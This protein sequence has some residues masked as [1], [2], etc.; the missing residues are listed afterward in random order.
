MK[1]IVKL[2]AGPA[3]L[4]AALVFLFP[5]QGQAQVRRWGWGAP[6]YSYYYGPGYG[7]VYRPGYRYYYY[8]NYYYPNYGYNVP[9]TYYYP[10]GTP[11]TTYRYY[12]YY[13]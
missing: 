6:G 12:Y 4:L 9:E 7:N 8:P 11:Y 2:L 5:S 3:V 1:R 13:R 10:D